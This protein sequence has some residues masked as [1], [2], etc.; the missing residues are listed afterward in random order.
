MR[1]AM[2]KYPWFDRACRILT[3]LVPAT[4]ALHAV[5]VQSEQTPMPWL[6]GTPIVERYIRKAGIAAKKA[7]RFVP[8]SSPFS[9]PQ[10]PKAPLTRTFYAFNFD[11]YFNRNI[12]SQDQVEAELKATG[13][14][15][16]IYVETAEWRKSVYQAHVDSIL[17]LFE[18]STPASPDSGIFQIDV[19]AF[20][21]VPDEI[22]NDPRIYILLMDIQDADGLYGGYVAGYFTEVNEYEDRVW[23]SY[24]EQWFYSNEVE[25]MYIDT[26]PG[27]KAQHIEFTKGVF[28]HEFQ[29]LIH[30][31]QDEDEV[32]WLDEAC[33]ELA[34]YLCGFPPDEAG[35]HLDYFIRYPETSLTE[36]EYNDPG[37]IFAD[38][39]ASFLWMVYLHEHYGGSPFIRSIVTNP[40]NGI[41]SVDEE[42]KRI[43]PAH[44]FQK[45]FSDWTVANYL[46]AEGDEYEGGLYSYSTLNLRQ[47]N[48]GKGIVPTATHQSHPVTKQLG[49]LR[50]W[51]AGY[52]EFSNVPQESLTIGFDGDDREGYRVMVT[53]LF[54]TIIDESE[55]YYPRTVEEIPLY[56]TEKRGE[57]VL[58]AFGS[59]YGAAV[60]IPSLQNT[61]KTET[62]PHSATYS[63]YT[64]TSGSELRDTFMAYPNPFGT[65]EL[66]K[67]LVF[68]FYLQTGGKVTLKL[69]NAAGECIVTVISD[70]HLLSG[71]YTRSWNGKNRDDR[72]VAPGNYIYLYQAGSQVKTGIV[73]FIR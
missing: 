41:E 2:N 67:E 16:Y 12:L 65:A 19:A 71:P 57:L 30:W 23:D 21:P 24:Q 6:S 18:H 52:I 33:A 36:W 48:F 43:D 59:R 55:T 14:H 28:A 26:D 63:Y 9:T 17:D 44:S 51:G 56:G 25:M 60:L 3:F 45:I 27:F 35:G 49:T 11:Q 66:G 32:T 64:L 53:A 37:Q 31:G 40:K 8:E 69:F 47:Y 42:L 29:H 68:D 1:M 54:D 46:D 22:D 70:E 39:G 61:S 20:G 34:M 5:P 15:C 73:C 72:Y 38:Y 10:T 13:D 7:S 58:D 62:D 4:A 50:N